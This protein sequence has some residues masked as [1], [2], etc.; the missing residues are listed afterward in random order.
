MRILCLLIMAN[1]I[2]GK[3]DLKWREEGGGLL[4]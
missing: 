2:A 3:D 4:K 1:K